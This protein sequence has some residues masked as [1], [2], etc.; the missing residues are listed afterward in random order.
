MSTVETMRGVIT[1]DIT[2]WTTGIDR[3]LLKLNQFTAKAKA[4]FAANAAEFQRLGK[5]FAMAG[6]VIT[7]GLTAMTIK[8]FGNF[9]KAMAKSTAVSDVTTEQYAEMGDMAR[10]ASIKLNKSAIE[11]AEGYYFLGSAGLNATQQMQA[12]NGVAV[13]SKA[14]TLGMGESAE[15]LVDTMKGFKI[16]FTETALSADKLAYGV[17]SANHTFGQLGES[18]SYVAGVAKSTNNNLAETVAVLGILADVGI[19]GS[20]AGT[21]LRKTLLSLAAPTSQA[22]DALDQWGVSAYNAEG[23]MKPL[24]TIIADMVEALKDATEEER[25]MAFQAIFGTRA[26]SGF[27][28]F[29]DKGA[30]AIRNYANEIDNAGGTSERVAKKQMA[31]LN[32]RLGVTGKKFSE[33][34]R[35]I[36]EQLVPAVDALNKGI[37]SLVD[38]FIALSPEVKQL[39]AVF[40]G[41]VGLG[42]IAGGGLLAIAAAATLAGIT[43]STVFTG[44]AIIAGIAAI[45]T[46][47]F[48]L[49][50]KTIDYS[51]SVKQIGDEISDLS[52]KK[53]SI[54]QLSVEY[55]TLKSKARLTANEQARL[56]EIT[57]DIGKIMPG[58]VL[59]WDK[60][61]E[62]LKVNIDLAKELIDAQLKFKRMA[63]ADTIQGLLD[64]FSELGKK[65]QTA[66]NNYRKESSQ[67]KTYQ[68]DLM[69]S[70]NLLVKMKEQLGE[71]AS[72]FPAY[73]AAM[74]D[75][76][77]AQENVVKQS[78]KVLDADNNKNIVLKKTTKEYNALASE[79]MNYVDLTGT[80]TDIAYQLATE[81]RIDWFTAKQLAEQILALADSYKA[82][83]DAKDDADITVE[84]TFASKFE[85]QKYSRPTKSPFEMM[86]GVSTEEAQSQFSEAYSQ[87]NLTE[88]D[89]QRS[90][91]EQM[92]DLYKSAKVN[93]LF[94]DTWY[95]NKKQEIDQAEMDSRLTTASGMLGAFSSLNQ[96]MKGNLAI[97][98]ALAIAQATIDTYSA[99]NKA[100]AAGVPPWNYIQMAAVIAQGLANVANITA[101]KAHTGFEGYIPNGYDHD[102][103]PI[104]GESGEHLLITPRGQEPPTYENAREISELKQMFYDF[105]ERFSSWEPL[106]GLKV[107]DDIE[108]S[109]R[110]ERGSLMRESS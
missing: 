1:A 91:L 36:G 96:A 45:G 2:G 88:F 16:P 61:G 108:F 5:K 41:L 105:I 43:M 4:N 37:G 75:Y 56:N 15:I 14:A 7:A 54:N 76:N 101:I 40:A 65:Q 82:L 70:K 28:E 64:S 79:L 57:Q 90:H 68:R 51:K 49:N 29:F 32:E 86:Y 80:A 63:Q 19:K 62:A 9:D 35:Q 67:L 72:K 74:L 87:I 89:A 18:I 23:K 60:H 38:S 71:N 42:G 99:A 50:K 73:K 85:G 104:M 47:I 77:T 34:F 81:F 69:N 39:I 109:R 30:D 46:A 94:L 66:I 100:L 17:T 8:G 59:A 106:R 31:T 102:S 26:V 84:T 53:D 52:N 95:Q 103:F 10:E 6:A 83:K 92:Y 13:L 98:K 11:L 107:V 21:T 25:N 24:I 97:T 20:R 78:Q 48:A 55:N 58:A 22:K 12:F 33:L 110:S 93:Q 3:A 44:V 27:I